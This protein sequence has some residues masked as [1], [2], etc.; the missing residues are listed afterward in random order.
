MITCMKAV[1]K[2]LPAERVGVVGIKNGKYNLIEY[3]ELPA[4]MA[5]QRNRNN[6]LTYNLGNMLVFLCRTDF[7][8]NLSSASGTQLY[9]KAFKKIQHC[10]PETWADIV[11]REENGWKFELFLHNFLPHV[12]EGKLCVMLVDRNQEFA[13]VKDK[14]GPSQ[15]NGYAV[16]PLPDTPSHARNMLLKEASMW[17]DSAIKSGLKISAATKG[18]IEVD[19]LL[20]YEGEK[21]QWLK[22]VH[23][24]KELAGTSGLL[25]FE[26]EYLSFD[27]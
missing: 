4:E 22:N 23:R 11:P 1:E 15:V 14:D 16:D 13:P 18:K 20:S 2:T 7:M 25:T 6:D 10:D 3:S 17:L 19:F 27:V 24:G 8:M 5:S 26:G 12:D 9:H 21:L